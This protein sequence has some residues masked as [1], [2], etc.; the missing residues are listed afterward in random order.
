M[1]H[2]LKPRFVLEARRLVTLAWPLLIA[3][4]TQMLMGVSDTI[5]AGRY[6]AVD[7]AAVALGFSLTIPLICFIQGLSLAIPPI[8]AR[9]HGSNQHSEIANATQQV[10]Y[11]V[12]PISL[13]VLGLYWVREDLVSLFPM[14]PSLHSITAEYVGYI[15]LS[16]PAFA[17]YQLLRNYCEALGNTKPTMIITVI[18][19]AINIVANYIFIYGAGPIPAFGGAGCGIATGLVF[20]AMFIAT[21][22]YT[23]FVPRLQKYQLFGKRHAINLTQIKTALSLG[24]PI[25]MTILFEVTL[26]AVVALLVAPFGAN[27]VAAHQIALNVSA[28][29]FMFPMSLGMALSI[30]VSYRLGQNYLAQAATAIKAALTISLSLVLLTATFTILAR[31]FIASLYTDE[32]SVIAL[33][34]SL[35]LFGALFQLS[36]AIQVICA[37]ALR[38]Y[39][40]TR[41]MFIITFVAYWLIGLPTG[42]ILGRTDWVTSAPMSAAGFWIGFIVGLSSAALMLGLRTLV[43]QKRLREQS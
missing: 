12:L 14:D 16:M 27:T 38:G 19:L 17:A 26:F 11:L 15:V 2:L 25:A 39:K 41:A 8:I 18:G 5:M 35:L 32:A 22:L 3:Q 24:L 43:I 34:A 20:C 33:A 28:V 23:A 4:I 7:M 13:A 21:L 31:T 30:R 36:D 40:D 6:S 9:L 29:I 37:N 42:I 10:A 1:Q